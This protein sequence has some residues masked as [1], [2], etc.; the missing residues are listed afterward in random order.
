MNPKHYSFVRNGP[1]CTCGHGRIDHVGWHARYEMNLWDLACQVADCPCRGYLVLGPLHPSTLNEFD[2]QAQEE[3]QAHL[4]ARVDRLL[5]TARRTVMVGFVLMVATGVV[6]DHSAL[7]RMFALVTLSVLT[8]SAYCT[9][10]MST[11]VNPAALMLASEALIFANFA[12]SVVAQLLGLPAAVRLG[13]VASLT[14]LAVVFLWVDHRRYRQ[15]MERVQDRMDTD[16]ALVDSFQ[17]LE[18]AQKFLRDWPGG[19]VD[20]KKP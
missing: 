11:L 13:T 16:R 9:V 18:I 12:W 17:Q 19:T 14:A 8:V 15:W 2:L 4:R 10:K 6:Q 20:L 5:R 3:G 1:P 7:M